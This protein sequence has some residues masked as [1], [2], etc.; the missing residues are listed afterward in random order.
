MVYIYEA[1]EDKISDLMHDIKIVSMYCGLFSRLQYIEIGYLS[2]HSH[3]SEYVSLIA[4]RPGVEPT[5]S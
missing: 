4:N 3:P 2:T 5:T 1:R